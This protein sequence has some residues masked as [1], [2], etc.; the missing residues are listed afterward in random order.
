MGI[1]AER[2]AILRGGIIPTL[3]KMGD[4]AC[5]LSGWLK[6]GPAAGAWI[7]RRAW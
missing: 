6:L 4:R 7:G 1:N 5:C 3:K 2:L